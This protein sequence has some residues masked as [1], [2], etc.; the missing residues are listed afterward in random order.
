MLEGGLTVPS[1]SSFGA[2]RCILSVYMDFWTS[3]W[4]KFLLTHSSF[5]LHNTLSPCTLL[6][7]PG[8][9]PKQWKCIV[10]LSTSVSNC[11]LCFQVVEQQTHIFF[12]LS[13]A[14]IVRRKALLRISVCFNSSWT[15]PSL[16]LSLHAWTVSLIPSWPAH[17]HSHFCVHF[18]VLCQCKLFLHSYWIED[19]HFRPVAILTT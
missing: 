13:F 12:N 16:I 11:S 8:G 9:R 17:S 14:S 18:C 4:L 10:V 15:L 5:A 1:A 7:D 19:S 3:S 2:F 6:V